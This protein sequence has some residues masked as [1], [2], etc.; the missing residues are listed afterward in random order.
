MTDLNLLTALDPARHISDD[1]VH[2][3]SARHA[4]SAA[5]NREGPVP[6][7]SSLSKRRKIRAA[8][9]STPL[10]AASGAAAFFALGTA[11]TSPAFAS[12]HAVP[13]T[14]TA[15]IA[16]EAEKACNP[17]SAGASAAGKSAFTTR[18]IE[19]RGDFTYI[20][21][22]SA[23]G[24]EGTCLTQGDPLKPKMAQGFIA[25]L[26]GA[27]RPDGLLTNSVRQVQGDTDDEKWQEVTG[28]MGS[29]VASLEF[30]A[31][32]TRVKATVKN[33]Y[34]AAWW[35]GSQSRFHYGPPNPDVVITL[36][37]GRN[38]TKQ[39]QDFDISPM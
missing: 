29:N 22:G 23:D 25:P 33:G 28:K 24:Y 17:S 19:Q 11:G 38:I 20:V 31:N 2:T 4:L 7:P 35:P 9:V 3:P 5:M 26:K 10:V 14:P 8:L 27:P 6:A 12:W 32:G 34:F 16:A 21:M 37:D 15:K 30:L 18:L 13:S 36:K 39:I 1:I